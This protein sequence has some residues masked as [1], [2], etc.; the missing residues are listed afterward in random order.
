M[1]PGLTS[2]YKSIYKWHRITFVIALVLMHSVKRPSRAIRL[3][4]SQNSILFRPINRLGCIFAFSNDPNWI[5]YYPSLIFLDFFLF[6]ELRLCICSM[7]FTHF[8]NNYNIELQSN[9]WE[10]ALVVCRFYCL[11]CVIDGKHTKNEAVLIVFC[12]LSV[13]MVCFYISKRMFM[14]NCGKD[15][16]K[17]M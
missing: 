12:L 8:D 14:A 17:S 10:N 4:P 7:C 5:F 3:Q 1:M 6:A 13:R 15:K 16:R 2:Y 9:Q 11:P